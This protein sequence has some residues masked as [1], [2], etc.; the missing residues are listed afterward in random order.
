MRFQIELE[1]EEDGRWI[2]E[3]PTIPGALC[4]GA[5]AAQAQARVLELAQDIADYRQ[6]TAVPAE[7]AFAFWENEKDAAYNVL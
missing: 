2:A 5:T 4:Y 1:Q 3:I 6:G 7:K